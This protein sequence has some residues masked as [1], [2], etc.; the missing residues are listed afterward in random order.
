ME[1][2]QCRFSKRIRRFDLKVTRLAIDELD[3][4]RALS[5]TVTSSVLRTGRVSRVLGLATVS[6][7]LNEVHRSV[8]SAREIG[9]I[10]V[11]GELL[12]LEVELQ[13]GVFIVQKVDS[14]ANVGVRALRNEVETQR[15]ASRSDTVDTAVICT[16]QGAILQKHVSNGSRE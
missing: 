13:V 2:R 3:V 1:V 8:Q 15:V 6:V 10:D 14:G 5:V 16:V 11:E 9:H 12:V 7:H 4:V